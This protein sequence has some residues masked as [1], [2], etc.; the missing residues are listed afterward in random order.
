MYAG[1]QHVDGHY[2]VGDER[3]VQDVL[4]TVRPPAARRVQGKARILGLI[5]GAALAG[6]FVAFTMIA[7]PA[8]TE[9]GAFPPPSVRSDIPQVA[10]VDTGGSLPHPPESPKAPVPGSAGGY[11]PSSLNVSITPATPKSLASATEPATVPPEPRWPGDD[12]SM[13]GFAPNVR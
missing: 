8:G 4:T 6:L 13:G 9:I 11:A 1:Q 3:Q 10:A 2:A 12:F 7:G 5:G